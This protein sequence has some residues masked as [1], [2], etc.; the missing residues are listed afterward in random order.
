MRPAL[1]AP[2]SIPVPG[3]KDVPSSAHTRFVL[4]R[5]VGRLVT[6]AVRNFEGKIGFVVEWA[7]DEGTDFV[8]AHEVKK[9]RVF[10]RLIGK[11]AR[12]GAESHVDKDDADLLHKTECEVREQKK[13]RKRRDVPGA[14]KR[15]ELLGQ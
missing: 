2:C 1:F 5:Y 12:V 6:C 15:N 9:A 13:E 4:C 11:K 8:L 3:Y 14:C 10:R 7:E